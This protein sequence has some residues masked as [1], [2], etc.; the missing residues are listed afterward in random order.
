MN[1]TRTKVFCSLIVGALIAFPV[2]FS[3]GHDPYEMNLSA[4]SMAPSFEKFYGTDELGRDIAARVSRIL[5]YHVVITWSVVCVGFLAGVGA[6]ATLVTNRLC[7]FSASLIW[8]VSLLASLPIALCCFAVALFLGSFSDVGFYLV[9][10][11]NIFSLSVTRVHTLFQRDSLLNH[12]SAN[13]SFGGS[14]RYRVWRYGVFGAWLLPLCNFLILYMQLS[15]AVEAALGYM[16]MGVQDPEP[17]FGNILS[18]Y[19][20]RISGGDLSILVLIFVTFL[21]VWF[22]PPLLQFWVTQLYRRVSR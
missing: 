15:V 22:S 14:N 10:F 18:H 17:S 6:G 12:W 19:F 13:R 16:K 5:L 21:A 9:I 2:I 1:P 8:L 20:S 3:H 7:G 11:A 4:T